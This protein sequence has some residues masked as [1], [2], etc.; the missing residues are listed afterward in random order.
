MSDKELEVQKKHELETAAESTKGGPIFVP[1]VDI[2]ENK[3]A[4]TLVIDM[5]GVPNDGLRVNLENNE[6]S[7][8]GKVNVAA[9]GEEVYS[10]FT[11]GDYSRSFVVSEYID[12]EKIDASLKDGVLRLRLPKAEALKPRKIA[13][14]A[15]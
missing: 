9:P 3:D 13:I 4:L 7:V 1:K 5:P 2:F 10:E 14:K 12:R 8:Y 6:L 15:G 11:I